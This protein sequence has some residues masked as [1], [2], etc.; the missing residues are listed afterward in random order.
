[1]SLF[2][3]SHH[4]LISSTLPNN[5]SH[6]QL[7]PPL[8]PSLTATTSSLHHHHHNHH[9]S[10]HIQSAHHDLQQPLLTA[11][12]PLHIR[13]PP[14]HRRRIISSHNLH[15]RRRPALHR[16]RRLLL[17]HRAPLPQA[18]LRQGPHRRKGRLHRRR[19]D[20]PHIPRSV[21]RQDWP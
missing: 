13:H 20:Q 21:R 8:D 5:L 17:G 12:P 18:L 1:M 3:H 9:T 11:L 7:P 15:P 16:R 14:L 2:I 10:T 6:L 4:H 19:P